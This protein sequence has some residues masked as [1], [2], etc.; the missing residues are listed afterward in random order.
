MHKIEDEDQ[1]IHSTS[2]LKWKGP[3]LRHP[4]IRT[5]ETKHHEDN[6]SEA[7]GPEAI[8]WQPMVSK[9]KEKCPPIG[10]S[11][12]REAANRQ[13]CDDDLILTQILISG[14]YQLH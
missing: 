10:Q 3:P 9:S 13:H 12:G 14:S 1:S 6:S 8:K 4:R 5:Q 7:V 11:G 2:K